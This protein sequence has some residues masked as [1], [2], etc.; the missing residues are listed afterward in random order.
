MEPNSIDFPPIRRHGNVLPEFLRAWE[1]ALALQNVCVL[2][3]MLDKHVVCMNPQDWDV[4][5]LTAQEHYYR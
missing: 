3:I 4:F 5:I 2:K 1:I